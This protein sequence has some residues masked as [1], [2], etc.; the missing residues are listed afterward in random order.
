MKVEQL[1]RLAGLRIEDV[2]SAVLGAR[3]GHGSR[4]H[5]RP[6]LDTNP[7]RPTTPTSE[8]LLAT[9]LGCATYH[10]V[11]REVD[12]WVIARVLD[13]ARGNISHAAQRLCVSRRTLRQRWARARA[14]APGHAAPTPSPARAPTGDAATL[15][16]PSLAAML[17]DG[18]TYAEIRDAV[19][20]WLIGN[21]LARADGNVT[22]A[23]RNL[24]IVRKQVRER[25]ARVRPQ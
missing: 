2:V 10:D 7:P 1:A 12:R 3:R 19:D 9:M 16:P 14:L 18:H 24:G 20:R 4:L 5:P 8:P 22:H 11:H 21:T 17:D 23:A 15:A 6:L 13:E 25:W